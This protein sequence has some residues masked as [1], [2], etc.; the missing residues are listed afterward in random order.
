MCPAVFIHVQIN[1]DRVRAFFVFPHIDQF[2]VLA[3][4]R[5]LL[6][7]VVCIGNKRLAPLIL[8]ERLEEIDDLL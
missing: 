3:F 6:L 1:S 8:W 7:R 4:T 5:L 2:E